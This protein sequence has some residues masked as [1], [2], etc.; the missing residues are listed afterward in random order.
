MLPPFSIKSLEPHQ[1]KQ[2]T[3]AV[4]FFK[5]D[6]RLHQ[7]KEPGLLVNCDCNQL[8]LSVCMN[9]K[10]FYGCH[11]T[12]GANHRRFNLLFNNRTGGKLVAIPVDGRL[13]IS[14][15]DAVSEVKKGDSICTF[16]K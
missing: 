15:V 6:L 14:D 10:S 16:D 9:K 1:N 2:K 3:N 5:Q 4:Y 8:R 12:C 13:S 7:N 11:H